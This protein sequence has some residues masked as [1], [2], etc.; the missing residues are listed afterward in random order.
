M[1]PRVNVRKYICHTRGCGKPGFCKGY[2]KSC[3]AKIRR[4]GSLA[5]APKPRMK[6][7]VTA[8]SMEANR[9]ERIRSIEAQIRDA[10]NRYEVVVGWKRRVEVA[11]ELRALKAELRALK[12]EL[13]KE[14]GNAPKLKGACA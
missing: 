13:A 12:A 2:C 10:S 5:A 1:K 4:W 9:R 8:S 14:V 7:T 6:K 3:D 11:A